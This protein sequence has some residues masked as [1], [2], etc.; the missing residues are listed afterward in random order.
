MESLFGKLM[1]ENQAEASDFSTP[2]SIAWK[3]LMEDYHEDLSAVF[4]GFSP[5]E[6]KDEDPTS[7]L[8]EML[9]T[10]CMEMISHM[11][12][13]MHSDETNEQTENVVL[14]EK[15]F[16]F[17]QFFPQVKKIMTKASIL[18]SFNKYNSDSSQ[19]NI[20]RTLDE[21]YCRTIFRFNKKDLHY[22]DENDVPDEVNYHF[23]LNEGYNKTKNLREIYTVIINKNII[24]K[25]SFD[26]V[27]KINGSKCL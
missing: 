21:R 16:D 12:L 9:L 26:R 22:F 11:A 15:D 8:F 7:F 14:R 10:I 20:K 17:E 4:L 5:D 13:I 6:G 24:Y 25:L 2:Q 23:I 18:F 3:L 1:E 27:Q 19:Q